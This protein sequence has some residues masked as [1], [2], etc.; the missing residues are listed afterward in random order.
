MLA[1][2]LA[3]GMIIYGAIQYTVSAGNTT[4]QSDARD[5]ILKPFGAWLYF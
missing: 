4:Q 1:G 5:R 3:F 2:M